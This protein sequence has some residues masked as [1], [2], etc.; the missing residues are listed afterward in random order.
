MQ[1]IAKDSETE[2][3]INRSRFIAFAFRVDREEVFKEKLLT[4]RSL[5]PGA[6]HYVYAYVIREPGGRSCIRS[7]DDGEPHGSSGKPVL[8]GM[9]RRELVNTAVV[10]VRYFG[11]IKLGVGGLVRAYSQCSAEAL[12]MAG[13]VPVFSVQ[14]GATTVPYKHLQETER[15]LAGQ[16]ARIIRKEY[17]DQ[18]TIFWE[19]DLPE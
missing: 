7:C 18:V 12:E 19:K 4:I 10:V 5:H 15:M 14:A 13:A 2:L 6:N 16:H 11:G 3:V 1:R 8:A 9:I 17:L